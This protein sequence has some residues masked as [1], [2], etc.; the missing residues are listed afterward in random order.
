M[1]ELSPEARE[2]QI[3]RNKQFLGKFLE[4]A[5]LLG[6]VSLRSIAWLGPD[7][8]PSPPRDT[9]QAIGNLLLGYALFNTDRPVEM[10]GQAE[11]WTGYAPEGIADTAPGGELATVIPF[12]TAPA[13]LR[14]G[15]RESP[16][17]GE[18]TIYHLADYMHPA[19]EDAG[20]GDG[21]AGYDGG[22]SGYDGGGDGSGGTGGEE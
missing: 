18:A 17:S 4:V 3:K 10:V 5:P 6:D 19:T 16:D 1:M 13:R 11:P 12:S 14:Q 20:L 7:R 15:N 9:Y 8:S 2:E 21:S 22:E